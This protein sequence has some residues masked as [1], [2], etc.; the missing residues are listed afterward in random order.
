MMRAQ[1]L[2]HRGKMVFREDAGLRH[3]FLSVS[4]IAFLGL[5]YL[6]FILTLPP[7]DIWVTLAG[8]SESLSFT[9]FNPEMAAFRANGM[10]AVAID[11]DFNACVDAV[12]VPKS[13]SRIE[14]R[15][16]DNSYFRITLDP[17]PTETSAATIKSLV[18]AATTAAPAGSLILSADPTC[19]GTPSVRLPIWG[20]AS[21]GEESRPIGP[22]GDIVP[23]IMTNA[24]LSVFARSHS[25]LLGLAFPSVVYPVTSF[26]IPAGSVL[27][28]PKSDKQSSVLEIWDGLAIVDK[29]RS[30]FQIEATTL[31]RQLAMR[32]PRALSLNGQR[33]EQLDLGKFAQFLSD[34]NVIQVQVVAGVFLFLA[35]S[36]FSILGFFGRHMNTRN[37]SQE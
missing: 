21:F 16:G 11:S 4:L 13:G 20:R 26:E 15:R 14:Y 9:V 19:P 3:L 24:K 23:G 33:E 32:Q 27:E 31:S 10:R 37:R 17:P 7:P 12:V 30:G 22:S 6:T 25:R 8:S 1:A 29:L 35:Q 18:Q 28:L 36:L 5:A 34:P 2:W